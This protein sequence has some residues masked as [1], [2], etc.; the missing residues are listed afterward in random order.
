MLVYASVLL[1]HHC[2]APLL[3]IFRPF[4]RV[5]SSP[6]IQQSLRYHVENGKELNTV[7]CWTAMPHNDDSSKN[8]AMRTTLNGYTCSMHDST[9][10]KMEQQEQNE[11]ATTTAWKSKISA[12]KNTRKS[13]KKKTIPLDLRKTGWKSSMALFIEWWK[14]RNDG[15]CDSFEHWMWTWTWTWILVSRFNWKLCASTIHHQCNKLEYK[16]KI[17]ESLCVPRVSHVV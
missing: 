13:R 7:F 10:K 2:P 14:N 12:G 16:Q 1:I 8:S 4:I 5:V 17:E 11:T 15:C 3:A 6:V 9:L